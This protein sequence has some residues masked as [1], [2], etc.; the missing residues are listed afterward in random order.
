[1][2]F[3]LIDTENE[4]YPELL[5]EI[6]SPPSPLYLMGS[7]PDQTLPTV[8][9]VGTRKAS[10][11]GRELARKTAKELSEAGVVI[12]SGLAMGIDTEA[13]KGTLEA[14]GVTI[15]V[16]GNG[17]DSVYPAQNEKLA[18]KILEKGGAIV[19]EY[20]PGEPSYRNRFIERNRI[21]SGLSLG[22][23]VIEAP[24]RSGALSTARFAGEEGRSVFVFPNSP[25]NKNYSG[26]HALIRDGVTLVTDT[27]E[28]LEDL[29]IKPVHKT[30]QK[31]K[32][33]NEDEYRVLR[34]VANAGKPINIDM[35]IEET[36]LDPHVASNVIA[37][38]VI[39]GIIKE[40]NTGYEISNS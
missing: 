25:R 15:A 8:A 40:G 18:K 29:G 5:M 16:L 34:V 9:I 24:E 27:E 4:N 23:V 32:N 12:V 6:Q 2:H 35:I 14:G 36:T 30:E 21:I 28:I 3:S 11:D 13:H 1:M 17:I 31:M 26:S 39:E 38:L 10:R 20:G 19:S 33:L 22:V 7:L 37:T